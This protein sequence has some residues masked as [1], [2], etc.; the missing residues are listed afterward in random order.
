[1]K[2]I[3]QMGAKPF[4]EAMKTLA[5]IDLGTTKLEASRELYQA[6]IEYKAHSEKRRQIATEIQYLNDEDWMIDNH[7]HLVH[8]Y[9]H[10]KQL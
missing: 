10:G 3:K 6:T 2:I 1:M 7:S 8:K 5:S 4:T 9:I